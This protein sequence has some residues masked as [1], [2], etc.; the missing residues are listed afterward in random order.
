MRS[1][2]NETRTAKNATQGSAK[3]DEENLG[4]TS[5]AST[6]YMLD[7][8]ITNTKKLSRAEADV[9]NLYLEGY[10]AQDIALMLSLSVNTIKTHNRRIFA[11]L[12]VSSRKE[13][14]FLIQV[15]AASGRLLDDSR[16]KQLDK[17][18]NIV[19]NI[20]DTPDDKV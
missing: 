1:K 19:K 17:I 15:L 2:L 13:L 14:L 16:Q 11:K 12:N 9:F 7:S 18:R 20:K 5:E 4:K 6:E 10:T 3:D 8:F